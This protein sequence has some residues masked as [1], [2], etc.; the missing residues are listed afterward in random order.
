MRLS[1]E[2]Y[3]QDTRKVARR[4]L[5][6]KLVSV[7]DNDR[8]EGIIVETEAYLHRNDPACHA[9][10][11]MT[12]RN[13]VMFSSPG[14]LYVYTI[15]TRFCMNVVT[16]P[17]GVGA[18]VL[19]RALQ[20]VAGIESME[21]CRGNSPHLNRL[22]NLTNGPGKLCQALG[23]DLQHNGESLILGENLWIETCVTPSRFKISQSGRIGISQGVDLK[24]RFFVDGNAFVSGPSRYHRTKKGSTLSIKNE[25]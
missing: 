20:P 6:C 1:K 15:H 4:L 10:R 25:P 17:E 11:G 12:R 23:I 18:A 14:T 21:Q 5:G 22:P 3:Q 19:I 9:A 13:R 16:E 24:Y 2:F 7:I 8:R